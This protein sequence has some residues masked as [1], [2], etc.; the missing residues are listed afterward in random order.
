MRLAPAARRSSIEASSE[1][2]I[3][4]SI[5]ASSGVPSGYFLVA[6]RRKR[7]RAQTPKV[8]SSAR[9][10]VAQPAETGRTMFA[11]AGGLDAFHRYVEVQSLKTTWGSG[12]FKVRILF[13]Q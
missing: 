6:S 11:A 7:I 1:S 12:G 13:R 10:A 8:C 3:S 2:A 4:K 9:D 5:M